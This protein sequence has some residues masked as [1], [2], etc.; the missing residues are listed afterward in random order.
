MKNLIAATYAPMHHDGSLNLEIIKPYGQFLKINNVEG[1][2][3]NGS[4]GDFVSLSTKERKQLIEAWAQNKPAD[5]FLTNHVGHTNV[6]EAQELASHSE[7]LADAICALPPFYFKPKTVDSLLQYCS[8]IAKSAPSLPFY[9]YH[10]PVLTGADFSMFDFLGKAVKIIPNFAGIKYSDFN[11]SDFKDCL[12]FNQGSQNILFGVDEKLVTSLPLGATG[13][14]GSTYNHLAPLYYQIISSSKEGDTQKAESLQEKAVFF[15][16][17]LD[18][19]SGF[20]GAGKSFMRLFGLDM[21]SSR[22]PHNT[23]TDAQLTTAVQ[24]LDQHQVLPLLSTSF[25]EEFL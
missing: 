25:S 8:E 20:N 7:D 23:M 16:Q 5:F 1:A 18:K 17:I 6:R 12:H 14:V 22:F 13:W 9:Y 4:T 11:P 3:V 10:I 15:V 19:I 24:A 21:G 2:F